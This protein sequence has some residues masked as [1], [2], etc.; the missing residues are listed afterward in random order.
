MLAALPLAA[1]RNLDGLKEEADKAEG[2]H[3]AKLCS[4]L[5]Q[6]LVGIADQQFTNGNPDQGQAI[7][8]DILKYAQKARDAAIK[9]HDSLKQ[10]EIRLRETQRRLDS[11]KRTLSVDDRPPLDNVEKKIEQFRQDL[12][13]AMFGA[14]KKGNT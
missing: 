8:Q 12:L 10:T 14:K 3:Q 11:L 4:E 2:G 5:A 13:D 9:S 1:Q 6:T 7:V